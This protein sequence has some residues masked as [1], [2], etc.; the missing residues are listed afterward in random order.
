MSKEQD[1]KVVQKDLPKIPADTKC[2]ARKRNGRGY[3]KKPAGYG[4]DHLG[5]GRCK[6]HGGSMPNHRAAAKA[7]IARRGVESFGLPVNIEPHEALLDEL[8]RT[9]GIVIFYEAQIQSLTD[10][11]QLVGPIGTE[12]Q[13]VESGLEHHP[14]GEAN[15]WVRLHREERQH[16][17]KVAET[18]IKAGIAERQ[19]ELAE[20]QGAVLATV[21]RNVLNGLNIEFD[22]RVRKIVRD[23]LMEAQTIESTAT[24][25]PV[26]AT[27]NGK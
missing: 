7:E 10:T 17:T 2:N 21:I 16:L 13:D 25:I 18:C 24:P 19:V 1:S 3:C 12:G 14:R 22:D 27:T 11:E 20:Q 15:V 4:T 23:C 5:T 26:P 6:M 8:A 9:N